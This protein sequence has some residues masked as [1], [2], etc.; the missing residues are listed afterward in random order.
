MVFFRDYCISRQL[1][2]L[3]Q[4]AGAIGVQGQIWVRDWLV[5]Q[6]RS[7]GIFPCN[8]LRAHLLPQ[9]EEWPDSGPDKAQ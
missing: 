2:P 4:Q 3:L 9:E 6:V 8:H 1:L 5:S 7:A